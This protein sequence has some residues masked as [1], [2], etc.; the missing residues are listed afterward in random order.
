MIRVL[1][2]LV[3][4]IANIILQSTLL[5]SIAIGGISFN[6]FIVTVVSIGMLR[7]KTEGAILGFSIGFLQDI[8]YGSTVGFYTLLF[9]YI[10]FFSGYL[11]KN[12]YR[13]NVLIPLAVIT[14][15]DFVFNFVQYVLTFLLRARTDLPYYFK[16]IIVPEMIYTAFVSVFIYKFYLFIVESFEI[17]ERR[18]EDRD[19]NEEGF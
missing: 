1:L 10:G 19:S 3:I 7:G 15:A 16:N 2:M 12:F 13:D 17:R 4:A 8:F 14:V 18:R 5:K 9:L 11:N 6:L